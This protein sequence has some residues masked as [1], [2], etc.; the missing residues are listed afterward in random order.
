M[1]VATEDALND[2]WIKDDPEKVAFYTSSNVRTILSAPL[3][4]K[5]KLVAIFY[6]SSSQPRVWPAEDIALVRDVADRTWMAVEKART[7][8]KLREAQ[9]RL[10]LTAGTSRSSHPLL[11]NRDEPNS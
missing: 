11:S 4:K 3:L 5:G 8:Q 2:P 10:R 7:E 9:E 1:P 6:V